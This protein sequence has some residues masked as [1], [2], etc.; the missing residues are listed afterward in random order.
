M[1]YKRTVSL[2]GMT[3]ALGGF[4]GRQGG[5]DDYGYRPPR[6]EVP[7]NVQDDKKRAAELKR[8]RKAAKRAPKTTKYAIVTGTQDGELIYISHD[9]NHM[10]KDG[11]KMPNWAP[12]MCWMSGTDNAILYDTWQSAFDAL[13]TIPDEDFACIEPVRDVEEFRAREDV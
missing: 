12:G 6:R 8:Q 1:S 9:P 11:R 3:A 10:I 4:P 5:G 2:L 13:Q 7:Q